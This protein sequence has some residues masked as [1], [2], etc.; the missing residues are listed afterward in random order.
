MPSHSYII[1][2]G[3]SVEDQ[4]PAF[5]QVGGSLVAKVQVNKF[6]HVRGQGQ[7]CPV[8]VGQVGVRARAKIGEGRVHVCSCHM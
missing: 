6:E 4:S 8:R 2:E 1:Q 3:L 5:Q 7:G